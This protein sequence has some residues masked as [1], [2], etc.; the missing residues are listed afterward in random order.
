M[1]TMVIDHLRLVKPEM[2]YLSFR[3]DSLF[4]FSVAPSRPTYCVPNR[5]NC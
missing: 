3:D 4:R 1:L 5:A 2:G